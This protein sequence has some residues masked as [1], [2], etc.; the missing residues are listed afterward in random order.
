V[1]GDKGARARQTLRTLRLAIPGRTIDV[2]LSLAEAQDALAAEPPSW[3]VF[4]APGGETKAER[5][6]VE[7]A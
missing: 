4:R 7:P 5:R 1:L 2:S 6:A 3:S